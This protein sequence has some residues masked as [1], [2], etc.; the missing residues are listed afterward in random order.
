LIDSDARPTAVQE[1]A[2]AAALKE[3]AAA[4]GGS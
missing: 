4:L 2:A 3:G 1:Q